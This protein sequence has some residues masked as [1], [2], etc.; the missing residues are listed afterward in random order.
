MR[1]P[2]SALGNK[3]ALYPSIAVQNGYYPEHLGL[4]FKDIYEELVVT[5]LNEKEKP[6]KLR[7]MVIMEG[8]KLFVNGAY[9]KSNEESSFIYDPLYTMKTTI[10]GQLSLSM[11]I[12]R[13][14]IHIPDI[15]WIQANTK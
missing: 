5:R 6:K 12:E 1:L 15:Q 11:L 14:T 8:Y 7:D 13:L 3:I 2:I 10:T 9:G 4:L